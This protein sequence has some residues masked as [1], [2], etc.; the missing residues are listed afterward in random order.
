MTSHRLPPLHCRCLNTGR[1]RLQQINAQ[2]KET[3]SPLRAQPSTLTIDKH[4]IHKTELID[5]EELAPS[6]HTL[7]NAYQSLPV[8]KEYLTDNGNSKPAHSCHPLSKPSTTSLDTKNQ[9]TTFA[10]KFSNTNIHQVITLWSL[11]ST[12]HNT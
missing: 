6:G 9:E 8:G 2:V 10:I 3:V 5:P 11:R 4:G 12:F 1:S 7:N